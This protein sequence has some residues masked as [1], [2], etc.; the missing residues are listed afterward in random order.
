MTI[1][2]AGWVML[3][4]LLCGCGGGGGG[5]SGG[6]PGKELSGAFVVQ[7]QGMYKRFEF[8]PGHKV[9]VTTFL[10]QTSVADYVVMPD[11]RAR[12]LGDKV[13][14]LHDAG[15]RCLV[16]MGPGPNGNEIDLPDF[17]RYCPE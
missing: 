9:A 12:I 2:H 8:K 7:G 4:A 5:G 1:R 10:S 17:G 6:G 14:I 16:L 15:D 11:G 13:A 3:V